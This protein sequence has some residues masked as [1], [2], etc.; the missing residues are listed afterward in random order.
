M[1]SAQPPRPSK[2]AAALELAAQGFDVF[3]IIPND[4]R[5][6]IAGWQ[7]LATQDP[8]RIREWWASEPEANI[9]VTTERMLVVDIDPRKGGKE[10]MAEMQMLG[11]DFP[12]TVASL[13]AGGGV[14][15]LFALPDNLTLSG[16]NNLFG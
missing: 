11:T 4:K 1:P 10:T 15:L 16:G 9:G 12:S 7:R 5:P 6:L 8:E 2:M 3:P 13:T 14:H